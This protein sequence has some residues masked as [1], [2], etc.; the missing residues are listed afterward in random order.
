MKRNLVFS[1]VALCLLLTACRDR[2]VTPAQL[3]EQVKSFLQQH[4][5]EQNV[6][7]A[8]NER[9]LTGTTYDVVLSDGTS[10]EFDTSGQWE[11]IEGN[12]N[13]PIPTVLIPEPIVNLIKSQYPDA[14]IVKVDREHGD[15]EVE[16]A[17]GLEMKFNKQG[18]LLE[19]DH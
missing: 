18:A 8:E 11:K 12:I 2:A 14:L 9:Q 10:I 6:T 7:Y 4:F 5:P 1:I 17:N 13:N 16:L 15:Y 3:P 19:M